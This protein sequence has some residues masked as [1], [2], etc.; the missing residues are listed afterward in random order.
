MLLFPV[1]SSSHIAA[2]LTHYLGPS[3]LLWS[4][5]LDARSLRLSLPPWQGHTP[6]RVHSQPA[7]DCPY[8]LSLL[9]SEL[10]L[11]MLSMTCHYLW[12]LGR[13]SDPS[14]AFDLLELSSW[15]REAWRGDAH[16][17]SLALPPQ[18]HWVPSPW[19]GDIGVAVE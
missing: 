1:A 6:S 8:L 4:L 11:F 14:E 5:L 9:L 18:G 16:P 7:S 3:T 17:Q 10:I 15:Y 19:L 2:S 12:I 13:W